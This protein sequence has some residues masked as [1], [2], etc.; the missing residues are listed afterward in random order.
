VTSAGSAE[1]PPRRRLSLLRDTGP[2]LRSRNF[3]PYLVGNMLSSVGTWFQTLAQAILIYRLTHSAFLLGVIGFAQ[4]GAVMFLAPWTGSVADRFDRR[5]VLITTQLAATAVTATLT[6]LVATGAITA[7]LLI[8]FAATLSV[9]NAFWTPTMMAFVPSL[10]E[11]GRL[12]TALALNSVTFNVGRAVGPLLATVVINTAGPAWAFGVNA[13]SYL[14]VV[15]GI[16]AVHSLTTQVR[17]PTRPR[18]RESLRLVAADPRLAGLLLAIAAMNLATDPVITLGP[19]YITHAFHHRD[20]LAGLL[21]GTFGAGAVLAAFT[22]AYRLRGS[23]VSIAAALG[24]TGI[25]MAAFSLSPTLAVALPMLLVC[26]FGYL[27]SNTAT[28][29]RLQLE[30]SDEHRGRIMALWAVAFNGVRPVGSLVD[31]S[32]AAGVG[33]RVAGVTMALPAL[34]AAAIGFASVAALRRRRA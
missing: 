32:I 4:Y 29:T 25:G 3:Y 33:L 6:A 1:I 19:A 5:R 16:F 11:P 20:A 24:T 28:T 12:S 8:V 34:A 26:G 10:V 31:G 15:A 23:R 14:A 17:P 18:L 13:C 30:V 22:V 7:A 21:V 27:S 2:V 9:A